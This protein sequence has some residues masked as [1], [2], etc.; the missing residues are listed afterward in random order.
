M[1]LNNPR[2]NEEE[3][4]I[5]NPFNDPNRINFPPLTSD[6]F[7]ETGEDSIYDKK[8]LKAHSDG[9]SSTLPKS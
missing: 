7:E 4:P 8:Q 9:R 6:I 5:E 2:M 3:L 1:D